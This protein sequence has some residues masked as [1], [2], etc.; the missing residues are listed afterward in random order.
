MIKEKII[1]FLCIFIHYPFLL[2]RNF[3]WRGKQS[4]VNATMR[5]VISNSK[6]IYWHK[7]VVYR[8]QCIIFKTFCEAFEFHIKINL[9]LKKRKHFPCFY[10]VIKTS[11]DVWEKREIA[12]KTSTKSECFFTRI[13]SFSQTSVNMI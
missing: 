9:Y 7:K 13:S 5:N 10:R 4:Y 12:W 1:Y 6:F 2:H 3:K 8:F 11:G